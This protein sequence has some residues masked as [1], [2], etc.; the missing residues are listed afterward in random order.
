MEKFFFPV[1]ILNEHLYSFGYFDSNKISGRE[2]QTKWE[3]ETEVGQNKCGYEHV[4]TACFCG[5]LQKMS[6][7]A[8]QAND[9]NVKSKRY[10]SLLEVQV[11]ICGS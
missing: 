2:K 4:L 9:Y 6:L 3:A 5:H 8:R 11:T 1:V 7:E 10:V